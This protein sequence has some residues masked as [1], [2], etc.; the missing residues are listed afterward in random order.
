MTPTLR[1]V[2]VE[3]DDSARSSC[4]SLESIAELTFKGD[5]GSAEQFP[6]RNDDDVESGRELVA[7]EDFSNQT[8]CSVP[9]NRATEFPRGSNSEPAFGKPVGEAEQRKFRAVNFDALV[10]DAL[11]LGPLPYALVT[12]KTCHDGQSHRPHWFGGRSYGPTTTRC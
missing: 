10:V 3:C 12:T 2:V 11:I 9:Y 8:L 1:V 5:Q 6:P 7:T 4:A